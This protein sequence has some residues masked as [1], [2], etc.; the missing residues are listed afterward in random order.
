MIMSNK[1]VMGNNKMIQERKEKL[2]KFLLEIIDP[3]EQPYFISDEA[4]IYDL[5]LEEDQIIINK[6][7]EK[8][9]VGIEPKWLS[10]PVWQ[11]L[12]YIYSR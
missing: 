10:K 6:I 5:T 3:E 11:L 9:G 7:K 1:D 2:D 4:S 8:Y 12:D